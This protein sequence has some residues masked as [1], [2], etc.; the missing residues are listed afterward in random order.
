MRRKRNKHEIERFYAEKIVRAFAPT[1]SFLTM[2]CADWRQPDVLFAFEK[3]L[4]GVEITGVYYSER[5]AENISKGRRPTIS[6]QA[7]TF[8]FSIRDSD[9]LAASKIREAIEKKAQKPYEKID[10]AWLGIHR[11]TELSNESSTDLALRQIRLPKVYPFTRI[12]LIHRVGPGYRVVQFFPTWETRS[13]LP[14]N[15]FAAAI[16]GLEDPFSDENPG[17]LTSEIFPFQK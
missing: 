9:K 4:L 5:H 11:E 3:Q 14:R 2:G 1:A 15:S 7:S 10:Q 6:Q 8:R 13:L 17:W 12:F 16:L